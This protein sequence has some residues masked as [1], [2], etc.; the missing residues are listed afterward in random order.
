MSLVL[1]VCVTMQ[2]Y[3]GP[4]KVDGGVGFLKWYGQGRH[5]IE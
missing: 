1:A 2:L 3:K 4:G 5:R